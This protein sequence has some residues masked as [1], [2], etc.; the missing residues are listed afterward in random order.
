LKNKTGELSEE[1]I[2]LANLLKSNEVQIEIKKQ[3]LEGQI[4]SLAEFKN[5]SSYEWLIEKKLAPIATDLTAWNA[6]QNKQ[7]SFMESQPNRDFKTEKETLKSSTILTKFNAQFP[8][9]DVVKNYEEINSIQQIKSNEII[10]EQKLAVSS[11]P[12]EKPQLQ[13][14]QRQLLA[15]RMELEK[16]VNATTSNFRVNAALPVKSATIPKVKQELLSKEVDYEVYITDRIIYNQ[17]AHEYQVLKNQNLELRAAISK[18]LVELGSNELDEETLLLANQLKANETLLNQRKKQVESQIK[19]LNAY[20]NAS[21]YELLIEYKIPPYKKEQIVTVNKSIPEQSKNTNSISSVANTSNFT[22]GLIAEQTTTESFPINKKAPSGLVY[23]IQVGAFR[24][25]IPNDAF[26]E[27]SPVSGDVLANGLTCYMAG[28]FNSSVNAMS[29]RKE[30]RSL[31]YADAFIVAYCDGKR[32]SYAQ[33]RELEKSGRCK[34]LTENE[35][36]L[37]L[38]QND[39]I[40]STVA[41]SKDLGKVKEDVSKIDYLKGQNSRQAQMSEQFEHLFYTVQVGVFNK[42]VS[43][44][45]LKGIDEL[46]TNKSA[47]G[48]LRYSSGMFDNLNA[49]K[50]RR[51]DCIKKGIADAFVVVYYKGKRITM[52][53]ANNLLATK[54]QAITKKEP[55]QSEVKNTES[56]VSNSVKTDLPKIIESEI[57]M[58]YV[59]KSQE[60]SSIQLFL[61]CNEPESIVI[62]ER[63]NRVGVFTYQPD[64][65]RIVSAPLKRKDLS[66]VQKE[67]LKDFTV[68]EK[69]IDTT[70]H[71]EFDVTEQLKNGAVNDWLLRS[72]ISF[73]LIK[74]EELITLRF[75]PDNEIQRAEILKKAEELLIS[76][77]KD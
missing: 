35:L 39:L 56:I 43:T 3:A 16:K 23:R 72:K 36:L 68:L 69:N 34:A 54:G 24:K 48:F 19:K 55:I 58:P 71:V 66:N 30:I 61:E 12:T 6:L 1:L 65:N 40:Q 4:K 38:K 62:L 41:S 20:K 9:L 49:A 7:P 60:D 31:G 29:A 74:T 47:K 14:Q 27:F 15:Q 70:M 32:I 51:R 22:I 11:S 2:L 52:A 10:L 50:E 5:A 64:D 73:E 63:M 59:I 45:Q 77:K 8:E 33:G 42:P 57:S 75:L 53:D 13:E 67:Y 25:P 26:R 28:Y 44:N 18:K 76:E 37:S 17:I 21:S 46:I